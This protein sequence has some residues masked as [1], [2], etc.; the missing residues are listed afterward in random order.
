M[1]TNPLLSPD[2]LLDDLEEI[3]EEVASLEVELEGRLTGEA[4]VGEL[5]DDLEEHDRD[6]PGADDQEALSHRFKVGTSANTTPVEARS[7]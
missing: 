5:Q 7:R 2:V 1:G 3:D 6:Q 4:L